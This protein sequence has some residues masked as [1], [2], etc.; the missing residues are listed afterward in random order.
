VSHLILLAAAKA[1]P[2]PKIAYFSILPELVLL[3]GG[4]VMLVVSSLLRRP[5]DH[6]TATT[7]TVL[8]A[9]ASLSL[10]LVQWFQVQNLSLIHI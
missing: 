6:A 5:M 8:T 4:V 10:A 3:G 1:F 7:M 9:L 2:L